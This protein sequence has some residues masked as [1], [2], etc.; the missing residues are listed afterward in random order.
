MT[1]AQAKLSELTLHLLHRAGQRATDVFSAELGADTVTPRQFTVLAAVMEADGASQTRLVGLTGID[2]S[3]LAD[4][5][6]RLVSKGYLRRRRTQKDARAYAVTLTPAGRE[7]VDK[8]QARL[9]KID[10]ALLAPLSA[11]QATRF[12]ADLAAIVAALDEVPCAD[13][14]GKA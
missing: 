3:T 1:T 8:A 10:D 9:P 12:R 6:R 13:A 14:P 7:I 2:R 4:I 5:V 11:A